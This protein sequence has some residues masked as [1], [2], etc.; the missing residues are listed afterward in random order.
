MIEMGYKILIF[1]MGCICFDGVFAGVYRCVGQNGEVG[2]RNHPCQGDAEQKDFLPY[3]YQKTDKKN[4]E[5]KAK[6][7]EKIQKKLIAER[8]YQIRINA[9]QQKIA[10]KEALKTKRRLERCAKTK[11]KIILIEK[12]LKFGCKLYRCNQL[13][14]QL[15]HCERMKQRYCSS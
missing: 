7:L 3:V 12:K 15:A 13:K 10:E 8:K 14:E 11:E 9:R 2:F 5:K 4:V 6:E 1:V